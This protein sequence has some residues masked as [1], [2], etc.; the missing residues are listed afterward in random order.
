MKRFNDACRSVALAAIAVVALLLTIMLFWYI[1]QEKNVHWQ[2]AWPPWEES[3]IE[4]G[5]KLDPKTDA[6]K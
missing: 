4:Q 2:L 5:T 1:S 3:R 6:A